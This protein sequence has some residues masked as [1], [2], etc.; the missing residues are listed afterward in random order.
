MV[1]RRAGDQQR[2]QV[3]EEDADGLNVVSGDDEDVDVIEE[4]DGEGGDL[5]EEGQQCDVCASEDGRV[6]VDPTCR[7]AYDGDPVLFG[8]NCLEKGLV[9][10]YQG[11]EG[12]AVIVEP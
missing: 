1:F 8:F 11:L 6:G 5:F 7:G 2:E 12:V 4:G 3:Q 10:A 9:D